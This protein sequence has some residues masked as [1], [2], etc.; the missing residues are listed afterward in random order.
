MSLS[1]L[2]FMREKTDCCAQSDC[3]WFIGCCGRFLRDALSVR[4]RSPMAIF[5]DGTTKRL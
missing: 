5:F 3:D 4:D 2:I 1:D